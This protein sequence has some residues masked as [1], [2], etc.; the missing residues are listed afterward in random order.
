[1]MI[2]TTSAWSDAYPHCGASMSACPSRLARGR[3]GE[4]G[5]GELG[6]REGP[7]DAPGRPGPRAVRR[8][9]DALVVHLEAFS[10][11]LPHAAARPFGGP[12]VVAGRAWRRV[13]DDER[14]A[15]HRVGTEDGLF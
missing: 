13:V 4:S 2:A 9:A 10:L 7:S 8:D 14:G 1:M 6:L 5:S 15:T 3:G 11:E 12:D